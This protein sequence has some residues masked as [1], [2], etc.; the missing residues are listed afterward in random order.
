MNFAEQNHPW[1]AAIAGQHAH[2]ERSGAS[3]LALA[4]L[5]TEGAALEPYNDWP[6]V[7]DRADF[8]AIAAAG[9]ALLSA[10]GKILR[11][12]ESRLGHSELADLFGVPERIRR[13]VDWRNL[14]E[15]ENLVVRF[16]VVPSAE[17]FQFC[18][19]NCD[20]TVAGFELFECL[21]LY[22]EATQW[23]LLEDARATH[24][25][26]GRM[27]A[28]LAREK[29]FKRV[30]VCDWSRYRGSGH[31]GFDFLCRALQRSLPQLEVRMAYEDDYPADWLR[32]AGAS[33]L[34]VYRGFMFGDMDDDGAFIDRLQRSGATI[35][36]SFETEIRSNKLWFSLFTAQERAVIDRF[37]PYT[38]PVRADRLE[39][40]LD[41]KASL[42]FKL[43]N[44]NGGR[45]VYI[46]ADHAE[47]ELREVLER[48][49]LDQWTAQCYVESVVLDLPGDGGRMTGPHRLVLGVFL[50]DGLASGVNVRA[51]QSSKVVN[52]SLGVASCLWAC[53]L[54]TEARRAL[55]TRLAEPQPA[56]L[57][58]TP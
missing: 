55:L 17:G 21:K 18:E 34:L 15:G 33:D 32:E 38:V 10:Q 39:A 47:S 8:E 40:L 26:I 44:S 16:D 19:I 54:S 42:V 57:L 45:G 7:I 5:E 51:S 28:K 20:S 58:S 13:H 9:R 41:D 50:I 25:D 22:A 48:H 23:P 11:Q 29:G 24:D 14:I 3:R 46:G 43:N 1:I 31:F 49:G 36:N 30:L 56:A 27:L 37:V 35:I 2:V 12:L 4:Y 53:P 52:V 6:L